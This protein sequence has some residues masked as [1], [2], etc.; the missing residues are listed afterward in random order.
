VT[1]FDFRNAVN[2]A[3]YVFS[4]W[5]YVVMLVTVSAFGLLSLWIVRSKRH[6]FLRFAV[7]AGF[8]WF[9]VVVTAYDVAMICLTQAAVVVTTLGF[10]RWL[11]S[12]REPGR[13]RWRLRAL[14]AV[15][16]E[17]RDLFLAGAVVACLAGLG[18]T[19][20]ERAWAYWREMLAGG[21]GFGLSVSAAGL[22]LLP[23]TRVLVVVVWSGLGVLAFLLVLAHA[24][25]SDST[26]W[27]APHP[28]I[29]YLAV[30]GVIAAWSI[31]ARMGLSAD[32]TGAQRDR[33]R[34][35]RRMRSCAHFASVLL[36]F[37]LLLP[38][39]VLGLYLFWFELTREAPPK[40]RNAFFDLLAAGKELPGDGLSFTPEMT[41]EEAREFCDRWTPIV[42]KA[43]AALAQDW[44][45]PSECLTEP[46]IRKVL[47]FLE[48]IQRV[49]YAIL[50]E[51]EL[52]EAEGRTAD[53]VRLYAELLR[54][55][56]AGARSGGSHL[57]RY[58]VLGANVE[59]TALYALHGLR[60]TLTRD[61]CREAIEAL[62]RSIAELESLED[63]YMVDFT[64]AS[65][66][67]YWRERLMPLFV[68]MTH[69]E[70]HD[71]GDP[72]GAFKE[73]ATLLALAVTELA[74]E[75]YRLEHG[76]YPQRLS[77]LRCCLG[78]VPADPYRQDDFVYY[79]REDKAVLYS[80]GPDGRDDG[81]GE[82]DLF[83]QEDPRP[84]V[85]IPEA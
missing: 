82:G 14:T 34:I 32:A 62:Q 9:A 27:V 65:A 38:P 35:R 16:Y 81:G 7:L 43:R 5:L 42:Q 72:R 30:W 6:W 33:S 85:A 29:G 74:L 80:V 63:T 3:G 77:D 84:L 53:A 56:Q 66:P 49:A 13:F 46:D 31:L 12:R 22:I 20:P 25:V 71:L 68:T 55:G 15:R 73:H 36:S 78:V 24:S 28:W 61:E 4:V 26:P 52:A 69:Y 83:L 47:E 19:I 54:L 37:L 18:V 23:R 48:P 40:G 64:W 70:N 51:A 75:Q 79:V 50:V 59:V 60:G 67:F 21:V 57:I 1:T 58:F 2:T 45:V 11:Q 17:L 41:V 44:R 76:R 8:L 10:I 39:L